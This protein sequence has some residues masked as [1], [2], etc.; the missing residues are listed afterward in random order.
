M[1]GQF[2]HITDIHPDEHYINGGTISSSCHSTNEADDDDDDDDDGKKDR[3][4]LSYLHE[5]FDSSKLFNSFTGNVN[6][7]KHRHAKR[8]QKKKSG[9][10]ISAMRPGRTSGGHGGL[11][12]APYS[13]CDS[14]FSL[15]NVTFDWIDKNLMDEI[16]FIVWTGDNAR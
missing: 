11:Y 3:R 13:I 10:T 6:N 1:T 9:K 15:V 4:L 12:G 14:P 8:K 7:P 5:W 16:D 2:L